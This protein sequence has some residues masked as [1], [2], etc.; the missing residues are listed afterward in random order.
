MIQ[1]VSEQTKN[2]INRKSAYALPNRPSDSGMKPDEIRKAF[3]LP[4]T[5][6]TESVLAEIDRVVDE[7][8]EEFDAREEKI[9]GAVPHLQELNR[10][11]EDN[12][13]KLNEYDDLA[14]EVE[15]LAEEAG[16]QAS[17]AKEEADRAEGALEGKL[18]KVTTADN[19]S[20]YRIYAV[21]Q[22]GEQTMR[23]ASYFPGVNKI[24]IYTSGGCLRT[25][26]PHEDNDCANKAYVDQ[27]ATQAYDKGRS[28][29]YEECERDSEQWAEGL[30]ERIEELEAEIERLQGDIFSY[31]AE[32]E[33]FSQTID[34][35]NERIEAL[36]GQLDELES[37]N[38]ALQNQYNML[39]AEHAQ[40]PKTTET[41]E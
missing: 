23:P 30:E 18:D 3:W 27:A 6:K 9:I 8:N 15:T 38:T 29:G 10:R 5:D 26:T 25:S 39:A 14:Q 4:V 31:E 40:C 11:A 32:F 20:K 13:N 37:E 17:L 12:I 16:E 34:N 19:G 35:L 24:A 7:T 36:E 1:K 22:T 33:S 2:A 21:T 41:E 28:D